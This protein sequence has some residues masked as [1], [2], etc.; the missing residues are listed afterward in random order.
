MRKKQERD[1]ESE[2]EMVRKKGRQRKRKKAGPGHLTETWAP[3]GLDRKWLHDTG[4]MTL[5]ST[6]PP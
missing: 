5:A 1:R 4:S 6:P 3:K 2:K